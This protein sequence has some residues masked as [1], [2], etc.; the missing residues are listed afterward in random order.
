MG[1]TE[2]LNLDGTTKSVFSP[3]RT[4]TAPKVTLPF[5][6]PLN[7]K[8]QMDGLELIGKLSDDAVP[9]VF[10]D[11]QFRGVYDKM[12]YGN[13][14]T[15]RNNVRVKL[16]QM[17]ESIIIDFIKEISRVLIPSGQKKN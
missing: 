4:I 17:G 3:V 7:T 13:E 14:A 5:D 8:S 16:P 11:P 9:V 6:L 1:K 15:S 2:Q 10:F 12:Q